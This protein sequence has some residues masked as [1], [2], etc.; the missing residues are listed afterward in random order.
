M[1][2]E[3]SCFILLIFIRQILMICYLL[4]ILTYSS[5]IIYDIFLILDC[6]S[7][8]DDSSFYYIIC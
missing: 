7:K 2:L 8:N 1:C 4:F 6:L 3:I 5:L